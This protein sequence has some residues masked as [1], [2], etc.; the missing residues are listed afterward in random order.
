MRNLFTRFHLVLLCLCFSANS[1]SQKCYYEG[2]FFEKRNNIWYE[3]KDTNP[4]KAA[5][6]FTEVSVDANFYIGDNGNCKIAIPKDPKNNFLLMYKNSDKWIFKY[7]SKRPIHFS[8]NSKP[9]AST[10]T[11][12][13]TTGPATKTITGQI[14][15]VSIRPRQDGMVIST[16]FN[17]NGLRGTT[18]SVAV[19][20]YTRDGKKV[21]SGSSTYRTN[22][23]QFAYHMQYTPQ[24]DNAVYKNFD[25]YIPFLEM[26][27]AGVPSTGTYKYKVIIWGGEREITSCYSQEFFFTDISYNCSCGAS[28][29]CTGCF[30]TGYFMRSTFCYQCGGTGIC[31]LCKGVGVVI[32]CN[33]SAVGM[34]IPIP[35]ATP[36]P[37][38]GTNSTPN[39]N[40]RGIQYHQ[41][42][43]TF[44][45]GSGVSP[46]CDYPPRYTN[47]VVTVSYCVHCEKT[48]EIHTHAQCPSCQG[49]GYTQRM[50]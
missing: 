37:N 1:F 45:R 11:Y 49:K 6:W 10:N 23:N 3:Y 47:N 9:A 22:D 42:T 38:N 15:G 30:G 41:E 17:I 36:L 34:A 2:G 39:S 20:L 27:K 26:H 31:S 25:I 5:N 7:K 32:S 19:Y 48:M 12:G 43:C 44:C 14:N 33:I 28:G 13:T 40:S 24:Y 8:S 35:Q 16:N 46:M 18:N 4:A 29:K 50:K 21:N